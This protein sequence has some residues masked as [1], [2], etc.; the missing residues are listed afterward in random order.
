M[1]IIITIIVAFAALMLM[2][3]QADKPADTENMQMPRSE[4]ASAI[5]SAGQYDDD[6][7]VSVY[8]AQELVKIHQ[9][10]I[11]LR[12]NFCD[13]ATNRGEGTMVTMGIARLKNPDTGQ[14]VAMNM[15]ERAAKLDAMRWAGYG[16]HWIENNYEPPFGKIKTD[17]NRPVQIV[18][19][20]EVGDSLFVWIATS[21]V[22]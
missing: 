9:D 16:L 8:E 4:A 18:N 13:R 19:Q 14:P 11:A 3:C 17:F 10:D 1:R 15:A 7:L 21:Y 2:S 12:R 22:K 6:Y 5:S 20:A